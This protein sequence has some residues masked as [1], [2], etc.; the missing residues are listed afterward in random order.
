MKAPTGIHSSDLVQLLKLEG[1]DVRAHRL[2]YAARAGHI[3]GPFVTASGDHAWRSTD[4][5]AVRRYFKNPR[6]PGRPRKAPTT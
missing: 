1:Y 6:R 3:P 5:P 4:L 2:R